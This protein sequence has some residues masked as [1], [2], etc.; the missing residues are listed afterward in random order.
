[1]DA[2]LGWR[3]FF[4]KRFPL[5]KLLSSIVIM[6]LLGI[7]RNGTRQ[8]VKNGLATAD[9]HNY[10]KKCKSHLL[11]ALDRTHIFYKTQKIRKKG[12]KALYSYIVRIVTQTIADGRTDARTM[13]AGSFVTWTHCSVRYEV[14]WR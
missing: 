8:F 10:S 12:E 7:V 14:T 4:C 11:G 6:Y 13:A 9:L 2:R 3:K 5:L 1:M